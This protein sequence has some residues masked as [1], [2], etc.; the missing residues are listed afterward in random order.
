M[1]SPMPDIDWDEWLTPLVQVT[2]HEVLRT[3]ESEGIV[4]GALDSP[5][6][7]GD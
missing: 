3:A 6:A 5:V 7:D 2:E 4:R 1:A